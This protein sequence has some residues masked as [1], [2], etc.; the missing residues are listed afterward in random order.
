MKCARF[1]LG[2]QYLAVSLSALETLSAAEEPQPAQPQPTSAGP[3]KTPEVAELIKRLDGEGFE[4]RA[5]AQKRLIQIGK[6][7]LP[8]LK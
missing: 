1:L 6:K 2:I 7:A 4:S 8:E 3:E 5:V